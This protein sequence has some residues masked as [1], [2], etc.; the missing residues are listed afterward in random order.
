M[1]IEASL[2]D[3]LFLRHQ[4]IVTGSAIGT[5]HT[6]VS[7]QRSDSPHQAS[8]TQMRDS[9]RDRILGACGA[10]AYVLK[11]KCHAVGNP[12]ARR[13][14]ASIAV[15]GEQRPGRAVHV[16]FNKTGVGCV[17]G[18]RGRSI[19]A[20]GRHDGVRCDG[21]RGAVPPYL[22]SYTGSASG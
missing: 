12:G 17:P 13:H 8:V 7:D 14:F 19:R 1:H 18:D 11:V 10:A 22:D 16:N 5:G 6:E 2:I 4:C 21:Q 20:R 3:P 9:G 15:Q